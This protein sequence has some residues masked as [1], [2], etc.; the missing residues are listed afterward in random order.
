MNYV[1][2]GKMPYRAEKKTGKKKFFKFSLIALLAGVVLYTGYILYW[3]AITLLNQIAKQPQSVL[4]LIQNPNGEVKSDNGRTN[5]LLV[6]IDKRARESYSYSLGGKEVKN[7]FRTDSIMVVS[8]DK[9]TK[10][11]AMISLPRDT[12]VKIPAFKGVN[13]YSAKINAVY[14][15]GEANNYSEGGGLGLLAKKVEEILGIPIHYSSR[16]DFQGFKKGVDTL[17]GIEVN[18]E[19]TFDDYRYPIEGKESAN[20]GSTSDYCRYKQLHFNKGLTRMDGTTALEYA[21]SREGTN[22]EGNDFA[23]ARRQQKVLLA[24]REK[25][26]KVDNLFDPAKLNNLFKDFGEAVQTDLDISA[27]IG[28]YNLAKDLKVENAASLVLDNSENGLLYTPPAYQYGGAFVL[29]PKGNNWDKVH[30]AIKDL[31]KAKDS[32]SQ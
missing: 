18:V 6:G 32:A 2:L 4:S 30:Q 21:R 1:D 29:L 22:G 11:V 9:N 8:V 27:I 7:N 20:C 12:W 16:I 3:P 25:A 31:F 26:L 24:V 14:E 28:T 10:Q 23:R 17:G 15:T 5:Y 13:S 19:K